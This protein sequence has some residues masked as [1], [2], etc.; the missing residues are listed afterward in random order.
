MEYT[1]SHN[2]DLH[3]L[4]HRS[5]AARAVVGVL[6][7]VGKAKCGGLTIQGCCYVLRSRFP[8]ST[9]AHACVSLRRLGV[10]C[11]AGVTVRTRHNRRAK[12]WRV[13]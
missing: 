1:T 9:V 11:W 4:L 7:A 12:L 5:P 10:V 13:T 3:N 6:R 2:A 8:A